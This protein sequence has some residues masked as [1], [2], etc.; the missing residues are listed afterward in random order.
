MAGVKTRDSCSRGE[1]LPL[2]YKYIF[3]LMSFTV[4][5]K[6]IFRLIQL[7]TVLTQETGMTFIFQLPTFHVFRKVHTT[8]ASKFSTIYHAFSKFL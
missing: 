6:N 2:P 8:L 7:Y 5:N 1:I 4:N 3:S